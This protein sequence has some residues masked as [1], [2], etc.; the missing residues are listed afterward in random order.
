MPD[1]PAPTGKEEGKPAVEDQA[2]AAETPPPSK[3]AEPG[4]EK[5]GGTGSHVLK[6]MGLPEDR[7][8]GA[9]RISFGRLSTEEDVEA[10]VC[11]L[12]EAVSALDA[13]RLPGGR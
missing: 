4:K 6:A 8:R 12:P 13:L 5:K 7:I 10:L 1:T 11:A 2:P 3:P 9:L